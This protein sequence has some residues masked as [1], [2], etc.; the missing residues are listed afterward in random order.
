ML[1]P[2][3]WPEPG[4]Q[5]QIANCFAS[6]RF[7]DPIETH[8]AAR[9]ARRVPGQRFRGHAGS[10]GHLRAGFGRVRQKPGWPPASTAASGQHVAVLLS[11][12]AEVLLDAHEDRRKHAG[13]REDEALQA[14][15]RSAIAVTEGV[16]HH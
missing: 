10:R 7:A 5:G 14:A 12:L 1:V 8:G 11:V 3:L 13:A 15:C 16:H 2:W 6:R 9:P 4:L